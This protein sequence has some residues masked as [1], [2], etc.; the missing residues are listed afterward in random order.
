MEIRSRCPPGRI[1]GVTRRGGGGEGSSPGNV[2]RRGPEDIVA[3]VAVV[4]LGG[5]LWR[6]NHGG[7]ES[8]RLLSRTW[9]VPNS[10]WRN[11]S[12]DQ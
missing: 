1:V 11:S 8:E 10:D 5:Y 12:D 2:G 7:S 6:K 4:L 3:G 9:E